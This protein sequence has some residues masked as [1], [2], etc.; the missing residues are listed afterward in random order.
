MVLCVTPSLGIRST[1]S[2]S[3]GA[4]F[5]YPRTQ[6]AKIFMQRTAPASGR[7]PWS[8]MEQERGAA[9]YTHARG[10]NIKKKPLGCRQSRLKFILHSA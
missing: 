1:L 8:C 3:V 2:E 6:P 10:F 7:L 5:S 9:K 4:S